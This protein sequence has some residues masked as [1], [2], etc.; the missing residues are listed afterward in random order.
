[1]AEITSS[2]VFSSS[3]MSLDHTN[4]AQQE[5][6]FE[7]IQPVNFPEIGNKTDQCE[8]KN[9]LSDELELRQDRNNYQYDICNKKDCV[10]T[11]VV[12][13][14][15]FLE[16]EHNTDSV[17]D[18]KNQSLSE[19]NCAYEDK[20]EMNLNEPERMEIG[21]DNMINTNSTELDLCPANITDVQ[22]M[23]IDVPE[24]DDLF[25]FLKEHPADDSLIKDV[26]EE[27]NQMEELKKRELY[28]YLTESDPTQ[29]R[30]C[31][32]TPYHS[33][34]DD[35]PESEATVDSAS[36]EDHALSE[37]ENEEGN[38]EIHDGNQMDDND[39]SESFQEDTPVVQPEAVRPKRSSKFSNK[40]EIKQQP[41][42]GQW[43]DRTIERLE[44]SK[45]VSNKWLEVLQMPKDLNFEKTV[46]FKIADL[47]QYLTCG[48]CKG[49]LYEAS[50][51]TECMH[52]FCKNCIV[53][54]CMEVS[55][56]CPVCNILIHP[57]DPFVH[58]R[59]DR[60][61]QDIVY[62]IMPNIEETENRN[63]ANF[64]E[65]HPE[66][67]HKEINRST[68]KPK[69]SP[70]ESESKTVKH[71]SQLVSVLLE[72]KSKRRNS[73]NDLEKKFIR[74]SSAATVRNVCRFLRQ[75]LHLGNSMKVEL[76]CCGD[77]IHE[78]THTLE[79][80]KNK[81]FGHEDNL[82]QLQYQVR[83]N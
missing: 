68:P 82:M 78:K 73:G 37:S 18:S 62:K 24:D 81:F 28:R 43:T 31:E 66:L 75:K 6:G 34:E 77:A 72:A 42:A 12:K 79:Y 45:L 25:D 64:Y 57:T 58:I 56:H 50:T 51:I 41:E 4:S 10:K 35:G 49:Y 52:T 17:T 11:F 40:K 13:N 30:L 80:I 3:V 47:N 46:M 76:F 59:L 8:T 27:Q 29:L 7:E 2:D 53:R 38:Q 54:H 39:R 33:G 63:R 83:E 67:E 48:L 5:D 21:D 1:M 19:T 32:V 16:V 36:M 44:R 69:I 65:A 15:D 61:I 23:T 71:H 74:V 70:K 26:S 60:M 20:T 22:I 14:A 55:L 9:R